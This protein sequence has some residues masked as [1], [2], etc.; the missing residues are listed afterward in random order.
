MDG[1]EDSP[2]LLEDGLV[3]PVGVETGELAGDAVVLTVKD[4]VQDGQLWVLVDTN[5]TWGIQQ[6]IRFLLFFI[7]FGLDNDFLFYFW[8]V[9]RT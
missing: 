3:A 8:N 9:R 7:S 5:V 6:R 4:Y 1:D 2:G